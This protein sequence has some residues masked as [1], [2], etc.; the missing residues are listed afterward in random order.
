MEVNNFS[1]P[2]GV[3]KKTSIE[4]A[5]IKLCHNDIII[6]CSDG[7]IDDY[8]TNINY[9]LEEVKIDSPVVMCDNLFTHLIEKRENKDDATLAVVLIK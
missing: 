4:P 9:I 3:N 7:M 5:S 6:L 8:N 2:L 1:L